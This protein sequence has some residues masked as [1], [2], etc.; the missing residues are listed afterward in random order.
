MTRKTWEDPNAVHPDTGAKGDN[1]PLDALEIGE[2][3]SHVGEIKQVKALGVMG[4]LDDGETDWKILVIDVKDPLAEKLNDIDD[5]NKHMPGLLPSTR[6]WFRFYKVP[7]GKPE[8]K[9]AFGGEF[10]DRKYD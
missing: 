10:K 9:V 3:V 2:R 5:V 4:L 7:D 8:N 6:D 1:D